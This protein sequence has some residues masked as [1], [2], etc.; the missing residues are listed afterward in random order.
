MTLKS[1]AQQY[2]KLG[3]RLAREIGNEYLEHKCLAGLP[4]V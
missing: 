3:L 4:K 1:T 2:F